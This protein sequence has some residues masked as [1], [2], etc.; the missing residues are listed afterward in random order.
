MGSSTEENFTVWQF[1]HCPITALYCFLVKIL[2][3]SFVG[4]GRKQILFYSNPVS[5]LQLLLFGMK[6]FSQAP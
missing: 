3:S 5:K 2:A 6:N 1:G 4:G